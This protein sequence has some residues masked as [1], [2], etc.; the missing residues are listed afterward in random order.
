[1]L[2]GVVDPFFSP[3]I[4]VLIMGVN[5]VVDTHKILY[6]Y[7][8]PPPIKTVGLGKWRLQLL[9]VV[10]GMSSISNWALVLFWDLRPVEGQLEST[11][12]LG[13]GWEI[14]R[15]GIFFGG[16]VFIFVA[17]WFS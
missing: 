4:L 12:S 15:V 9:K 3:L 7:R 2:F 10:A 8:R 6:E 14:T 13:D 5:T 16:L 11:F 1:M 17:V